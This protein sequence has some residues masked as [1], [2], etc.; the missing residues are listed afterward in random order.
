MKSPINENKIK[1]LI[2]PVLESLFIEFVDIELKGRAGNQ[3]LRIFI[4]KDDGVTIDDCAN[5]SRE[6]SDILEM[7]D[8][9]QGKYRLEVSSPGIDRPLKNYKDFKRNLTRNI[10]IHYL[11]EN[12]TKTVTGIIQAVDST[13][14]KIENDQGIVNISIEDIQLAKILP[15]W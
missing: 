10:S 5:V 12:E 15:L 11:K 6:V 7:E 14:V 13:S 8:L 2:I 9:I 1:Q 3:V 4:A